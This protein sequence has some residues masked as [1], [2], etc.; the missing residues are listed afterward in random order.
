MWFDCVP[1]GIKPVCAVFLL[2]I[3]RMVGSK[4]K[5]LYKLIV[6]KEE[7]QASHNLKNE[8]ICNLKL[9]QHCTSTILQLNKQFTR[10]TN[11]KM[12]YYE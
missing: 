5:E 6:N 1:R 9:I 10:T 7:K 8:N 12:V 3:K 2:R 11:T 4:Q